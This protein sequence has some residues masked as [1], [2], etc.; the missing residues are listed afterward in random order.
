M[1]NNSTQKWVEF[2]TAELIGKE[3][4]KVKIQSED[5]FV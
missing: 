3:T 2:E 1:I 4:G 5:L